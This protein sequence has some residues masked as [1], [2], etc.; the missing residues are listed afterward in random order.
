VTVLQFFGGLAFGAVIGWITYFVIRR[1][2]PKVL[3]DIT[4]IIGILGGGAVTALFAPEGASFAGYAIGL[5]LGFFGYYVTFS[6]V[7]GKHAIREVMIK[8]LKGSGGA[9][10]GGGA[11]QETEEAGEVDWGPDVKTSK[12]KKE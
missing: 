11:R 3:T 1:A 10:M 5:A 7:V 6:I 8:S 2:Q 9:A 12:G 4:T